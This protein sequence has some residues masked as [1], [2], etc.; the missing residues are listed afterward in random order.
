MIKNVFKYFFYLTVLFC[1]GNTVVGQSNK[2]YFDKSGKSTSVDLGYYYRVKESEPDYYKSFYVNGESLYF[3]GHIVSAS[4][5]DE[6]QNV[7]TGACTWYFKNGKKKY[8][9]KFTSAGKEDG[10][11]THYYESGKI[12]KELK[13]K[14]GVLLT[15]ETNEYSEDGSKNK[16]FEENFDSNKNDWDL[17]VSDK[18]ISTIQGGVFTLNSL[19]DEGTSRYIHIDQESDE[20][21]LEITL[22]TANLK[23]SSKAGLIFGFKDWQN[24]SY[25][26]ISNGYF[27]IGYVFEG[28]NSYSADGMYCSSIIDKGDNTLKILTNGEKLVYSVNGEVQYSQNFIQLYGSNV[29]F[30]VSGKT[31]VVFDN[32]IYKQF[33]VGSSAMH[34][35]KGDSDVKGTGSGILISKDGYI[36][37]NFHVI[38]TATSIAVEIKKENESKVYKAILVQKDKDNDL[39]ILKIEDK[40][41]TDL[42]DI[43]YGFKQAGL[44]DVGASVFTIGFPYALSGMG[45]EA[46]FTDGKISAKTG[47]NNAV[48]SYQTSI[49]VQPGNSGGPVFNDKGELVGLINAKVTGADNVSYV[50]KHSY[51]TNLIELLPTTVVVPASKEIID[52]SLEEKI[53]VLTNY[54]VLIK[55][56]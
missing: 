5:S 29:G 53:K 20:F 26:L 2:I 39:A 46:K 24:F 35:G 3:E 4:E 48:N 12:W 31:S 56:K 8:E 40:D 6:S 36:I 15:N 52:L 51:I 43:K 49:P 10:V 44:M 32:L 9:R 54:V 42:N 34:V 23:G 30:A 13:Y 19:T 22:N 1:S 21:A 18:S 17:F 7:Y 37:T 33:E 38:E 11:S 45:K 50:I 14:E 27:Y 41:F 16:I 47:Y 25:F 55:I 28:V